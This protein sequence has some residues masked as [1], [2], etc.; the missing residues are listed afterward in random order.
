MVREKGA[1]VAFEQGV[2]WRGEGLLFCLFV[3]PLCHKPRDT[4][5]A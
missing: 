3:C 1:R 4:I 2:N 5:R